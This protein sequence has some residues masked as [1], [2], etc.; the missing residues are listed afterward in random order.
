[1]LPY[2]LVIW[3]VGA[4]PSM[5]VVGEYASA[6]SCDAAGKAWE[7]GSARDGGVRFGFS[8]LPGARAVEVERFRAPDPGRV[9]PRTR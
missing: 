7:A 8:C 4:S 9:Q 2:V 1:M 5:V 3:M 6:P